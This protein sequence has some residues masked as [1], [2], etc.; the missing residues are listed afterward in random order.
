MKVKKSE[1]KSFDRQRFE[2]KERNY[3]FDLNK[4]KQIRQLFNDSGLN[5]S[6]KDLEALY[7]AR[8]SNQSIINAALERYKGEKD[9]IQRELLEERFIGRV[10]EVLDKATLNKSFLTGNFD[11]K[12]TDKEVRE[13]DQL[14]RIRE[15]FTAYFTD[16]ELAAYRERE[17]MAAM[18]T[19]FLKKESER[20]GQTAT[21]RS[22]F[23]RDHETGEVMARKTFHVGGFVK[24]AI[25]GFIP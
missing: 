2:I 24:T 12:I 9:I 13:T 19:E 18:M 15:E 21:F 20:L 6:G 5:V 10:N 22:L 16:E 8:F 17:K 4:L 1:I 25:P 3:S 11:F 7:R 14:E 23:Y